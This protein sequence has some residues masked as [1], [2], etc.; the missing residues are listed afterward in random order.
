VIDLILPQKR[1]FVIVWWQV[2]S[3]NH[4]E[5]KKCKNKTCWGCTFSE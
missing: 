2:Q 1:E 4:A 5:S 3:R